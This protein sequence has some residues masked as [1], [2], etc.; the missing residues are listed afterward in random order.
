MGAMVIEYYQPGFRLA[1]TPDTSERIN[2]VSRSR[3]YETRSSMLIVDAAQRSCLY[4]LT[5]SGFAQKAAIVSSSAGAG[6]RTSLAHFLDLISRAIPS[7]QRNRLLT[8]PVRHKKE[9]RVI[10]TSPNTGKLFQTSLQCTVGTL[11]GRKIFLSAF[12]NFRKLRKE[13]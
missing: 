11:L 7:F 2:C 8:L 5:L 9:V 1:E 10:G 3:V 6:C 4:G 12:A 13:T